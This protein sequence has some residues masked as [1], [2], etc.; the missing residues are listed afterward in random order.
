MQPTT[1]TFPVP[2]GQGQA[3]LHR[4]VAVLQT[5]GYTVR[6]TSES[7]AIG[8]K[9]VIPGWAIALAVVFGLFCLV[10]LLFLL[11][12]EDREV[13]ASI[14]VGP[15]G[16][17]IAVSGAMN[18][19]T[20]SRL[21]AELVGAFPPPAAAP[22]VEA[23]L[24]VVPA[25]VPQPSTVVPPPVAEVVPTEPVPVEVGP[26]GPPPGISS[27]SWAAPVTPPVADPAVPDEPISSVPGAAADVEAYTIARPRRSSSDAAPRLRLDDGTELIVSDLVLVGRDPA[28]ADGET[29]GQLVALEDPTRGLSKT[30]AGIAAVDG[31]LTVTD[32]HSTNGTVVRSSSGAERDCEPGVPSVVEIGDTVFVGGRRLVR[33]G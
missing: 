11:I 14:V 29:A 25:P 16:E 32:R 3:G 1:L 23:S 20:I 28:A 4:A 27:V 5:G 18:G 6:S 7:E 9:R 26:V 17:A 8:V 24:P 19:S 10:G 13:R 31:R 21:H 33:I 30:H 12:K 15:D 22:A 2:S